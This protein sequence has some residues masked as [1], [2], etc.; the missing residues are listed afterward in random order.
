MLKAASKEDPLRMLALMTGVLGGAGGIERYNK[1]F[2]TAFT[3]GNPDNSV[4]ILFYQFRPLRYSLSAFKALLKNGPFDLIFCGHL[5]LAPLAAVFSRITKTPFWLQLHGTEA[6]QKPSRFIQWAAARAA[7]VTAVS[8][9]TRR[10]FLEW[11]GLSPEKVRVLPNT[12]SE[13]FKPGPKSNDLLK[14]YGFTGKKFLLTVSR[15]SSGERYKGHDRII[16]LLPRLLKKIPNLVYLIAGEGNDRSRLEALAREQGLNGWVR[17]LGA[18]PEEELP[19]HYRMADLYVM[20][21]QGE[22]F[23]IT[24]LEACASGIPVVGS[25]CGGSVDALREGRLGK[26]VDPDDSDSLFEAISEGLESGHCLTHEASRFSNSN[27]SAF[28]RELLKTL[29]YA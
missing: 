11:S 6:W 5:H 24:F 8:R 25:G 15:L 20:P 2:L 16:Q 27:F 13:R 23:G 9:Y 21:S 12:V 18:I 17:F 26:V 28:V 10:K 22:G 29:S 1:D 3:S 19:D 14:R 4:V 7:L